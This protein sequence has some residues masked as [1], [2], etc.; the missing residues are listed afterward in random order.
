MGARA[1]GRSVKVAAWRNRQRRNPRLAIRN[2]VQRGIAE[3][4]GVDAVLRHYNVVVVKAS[5]RHGGRGT[6]QNQEG[7]H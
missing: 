5:L 3:S 4:P 6:H 2:H 1:A 7:N